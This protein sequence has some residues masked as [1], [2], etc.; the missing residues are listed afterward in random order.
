MGHHAKDLDVH[1][2]NLWTLIRR[3][4]RY[5]TALARLV[6][7]YQQVLGNFDVGANKGIYRRNAYEETKFQGR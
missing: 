3:H 4:Q 1:G 6:P 5:A 7:E 2:E